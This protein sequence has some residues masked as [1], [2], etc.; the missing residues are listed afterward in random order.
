MAEPAAGRHHVDTM[1][2][3]SRSWTADARQLAPIRTQVRGWLAPLVLPGDAEDDIV[4]AVSEAATNCVE[5]AYPAGT[6][7]G[8]VRAHLLDRSP[9]SLPRV[10]D[11][12]TWQP[13]ADQPAHRGRGIE[14]MRRV[15]TTV[16]IHYD[17][18]GT[19]VFLSYPLPDIGNRP[20]R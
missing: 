11:H 16:L 17:R 13:P 5:H 15:M 18:R 19:R 1:E 10:V 20:R 9:A 4:L 12:G 14:M 6:S 8:T 7:G 3:A 2:F